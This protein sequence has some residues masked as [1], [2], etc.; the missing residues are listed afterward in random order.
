MKT[1][2]LMVR[3]NVTVE[4]DQQID[5]LYLDIDTKEIRLCSNSYSTLTVRNVKGKVNEYETM[6]VI[7]V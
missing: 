3:F 4:D 7:E 5:S 6:E 2:E 1:V